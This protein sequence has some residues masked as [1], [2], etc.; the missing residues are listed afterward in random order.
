MKEMQVL[1]KHLWIKIFFLFF[2]YIFGSFA[3]YGLKI[4]ANV[5]PIRKVTKE[6]FAKFLIIC[7]ISRL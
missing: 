5:I 2:M 6:V 3:S 1:G 4:S 7:N